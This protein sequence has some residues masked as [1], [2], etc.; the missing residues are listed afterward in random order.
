MG[1]RLS[2]GAV[3]GVSGVKGASPPFMTPTLFE[4]VP[5]PP[6]PDDEPAGDPRPWPGMLLIDVPDMAD[7]GWI[8]PRGVTE[9]AARQRR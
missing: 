4:D 3:E 1:G 7:P 6:W 8:G 2:D 5:V 9:S